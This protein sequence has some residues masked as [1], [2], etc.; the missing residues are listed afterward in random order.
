MTNIL[1][2]SPQ[3]EI[4]KTKGEAVKSEISEYV[5]KRTYQVKD[6]VAEL[7]QKQQRIESSIQSLNSILQKSHITEQISDYGVQSAMVDELTGMDLGGCVLVEK[8]M[9]MKG[10]LSTDSHTVPL[11]YC[12]SN[13]VNHVLL[14]GGQLQIW[15]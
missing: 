6:F 11:I 15:A 5:M 2:S 4:L 8:F 1:F 3:I 14:E 9:R 12:E 10:M 13:K 7:T